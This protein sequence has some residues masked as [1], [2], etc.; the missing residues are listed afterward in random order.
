MWKEARRMSPRSTRSSVFARCAHSRK[1]SQPTVSAARPL[2]EARPR[3]AVGLRRRPD[4]GIVGA[5]RGR[6]NLY[7]FDL[8]NGRMIHLRRFTADSFRIHRGLLRFLIVR[9]HEHGNRRLQW[10]M[11]YNVIDK[12][13]S[14]RGWSTSNWPCATKSRVA[15][16]GKSRMR[17]PL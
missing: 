17:T 5:R 15:P 11:S 1:H 4:E 10:R 3:T 2:G 9:P 12:L 6:K 13:K 7:S 14:P 8:G 16:D